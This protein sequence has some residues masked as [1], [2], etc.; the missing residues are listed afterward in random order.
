MTSLIAMNLK[1][2]CIDWKLI[3]FY[4]GKKRFFP[5]IYDFQIL[6]SFD[7]CI[8]IPSNSHW[9]RQWSIRGL[10]HT[11]SHYRIS[12]HRLRYANNF[13]SSVNFNSN[14]LLLRLLNSL[15]NFVTY[16]ISTP[17]LTTFMLG[18]TT[19]SI[20]VVIIPTS[21]DWTTPTLMCCY[22]VLTTAVFDTIGGVVLAQ[23]WQCS[24]LRLP[25]GIHDVVV[26]A[27]EYPFGSLLLIWIDGRI[28]WLC[29]PNWF[30]NSMPLNMFWTMSIP[31]SY[32]CGWSINVLTT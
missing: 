22:W 2:T 8:S 6:F 13:S 28:C 30:P 18:A 9:A 3:L 12:K 16:P 20:P 31:Y 7:I 26:C 4:L 23:N 25:I 17:L 21:S 15:P 27:C 10:V 19:V 32:S 24:N 5:K 29:G 1:I 14:S 11:N